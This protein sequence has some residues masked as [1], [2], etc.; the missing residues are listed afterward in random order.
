MKQVF[1]VVLL[2][3]L[4]AA[5]G[6]RVPTVTR[7]VQQFGELE[8]ELVSARTAEARAAL[9]TDDF[10]ER[11]CGDPGTP[12]PKADWL[13]HPPSSDAALS[14]PAV[15]ILSDVAS[16]SGLL[17]R[18][19]QN[20]MIVDLWKKSDEGWKLAVRYRCPAG[21]EKHRDSGPPKRY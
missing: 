1:T 5:Q 8:R 20:D 9:L 15:H 21:G 6:A 19:G 3:V 4:S 12:I 7:T 17:A 2:S 13:Q 10:E 14:Q 11:L 18:D 16:Y